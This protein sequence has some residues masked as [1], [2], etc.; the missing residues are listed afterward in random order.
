[1]GS[2]R[3]CLSCVQDAVAAEWDSRFLAWRHKPIVLHEACAGFGAARLAAKSLNIP[4]SPKGVF[5]EKKPVAQ[6]I[7]AHL[8]PDQSHIVGSLVD[9]Y[10]PDA[11]C[12]KHGIVCNILPDV[13]E[14]GPDVLAMGP[15][16]QPFSGQKATRSPGH[17]HELYG[18]SLGTGAES[19]FELV[20][21]LK[22]KA[23]IYENVEAFLRPDSTGEVPVATLSKN[24]KRIVDARGRPHFTAMHVFQLDAKHWCTMSLPRTA[25]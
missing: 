17:T 4:L 5:S 25:E 1:M 12:H 18:V 3:C 20:R 10:S 14:D 24:L 7:L 2:L 8:V 21:S 15:P 23:L 13:S 16:C 6:E 11:F 9:H 22:P 19:I